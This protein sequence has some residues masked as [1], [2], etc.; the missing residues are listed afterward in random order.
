MTDTEMLNWLGS[1][2]LIHSSLYKGRNGV[3]LLFPKQYL[4]IK[5]TL[6]EAIHD[7]VEKELQHEQY[8]QS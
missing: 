2:A 5:T 3:E 8:H 4:G 6:R 1:K 7:A